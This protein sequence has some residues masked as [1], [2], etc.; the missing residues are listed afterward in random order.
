MA[1]HTNNLHLIYRSFTDTQKLRKSFEQRGQVDLAEGL[2][3]SE[4]KIKRLARK[5]LGQHPL[6]PWLQQYKGFLGMRMAGVIGMLRDPRRFPGQRCTSNKGAHYLIPGTVNVGDSCSEEVWDK[7]NPGETF[8]CDGVVE[9]PRAGTG[10]RSVWHYSGLHVV[11][12]MMPRRRKGQQSDWR[13]ELRT[14]FLMPDGIVDQVIKQ[15]TEKYRDLYDEKKAFFFD[16]PDIATMEK[17]RPARSHS[18]ARVC[19]AKA[20]LGDLLMEWKRLV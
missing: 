4:G 15:R 18:L 2:E 13:G 12:G 7:E 16:R 9:E 1:D 3:A 10:V 14:C 19:V 17:G 8:A 11:D 6:F 5:E 20:I